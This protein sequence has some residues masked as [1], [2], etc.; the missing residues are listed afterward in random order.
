[1]AASQDFDGVHPS[2]FFKRARILRRFFLGLIALGSVAMV[3]AVPDDPVIL[4]L[5]WRH[6]FQFAGYYAAQA[7]GYYAE[8]GINVRIEPGRPGVSSIDAV[9]NEVAQFGVSDSD[10]V[11]TRLEGKPLVACAAIFQHSPIVI[12][13]RRDRNIRTPADLVGAK[14]MMSDRQG[15]AQLWAMVMREGIAPE[16]VRTVPHS[17]RLEDL[18]EGRVDAISAYATVEPLRLRARGIEPAVLRAIDYGVDFYGDM[19]FTNEREARSHPERTDAF[20]RASLKGWDYALRNPEEIVDLILKLDG[21]KQRG[22]TRESLLEEAAALRPFILPDIVE[23]GHINP[24]R[25]RQ[26]AQTFSDLK[27]VPPGATLEGFIY[28]SPSKAEPLA[29]G[30]LFKAGAATAFGVLLVLLWNLQ[31][32]RRV[33][34]RTRQLKEE[35]LLRARIETELRA[36]EER[37]RLM[38]AGAATG[39]AVTTPDGRFIQANPAYLASVGYSEAELQTL[40]LTALLHPDDQADYRKLVETLLT[41]TKDHFVSEARCLKREGGFTWK[42]ASV[43]LVRTKDGQ[44][45]SIIVV[46]EDITARREAEEAASASAEL[47]RMAS[48]IGGM[49]AWAIEYPGARITWSDE[50][51]RIHEVDTSY[52]PDQESALGFFTPASRSLL[53]AAIDAAE[54]YDLELEL[55]TAKGN[56]RWVRTTSNIEREDGVLKRIYGIFQDITDRKLAREKLTASEAQYRLLFTH[57]P[58]PMWVCEDQTLRFLAVNAAASEHYGYSEAEF[59][60]MTIT[61]LRAPG[62][63]GATER[64][65]TKSG[66][67]IDIEM[68][69]DQIVFDDRPAFLTMAHDV[70]EL[71]RVNR[72]QRMLSACNEALI[73]TEAENDLLNDICRIAVEIGGYRMAWVGFALQ[74]A[75]HSIRPVA[76]AG[77]ESGYLSE[78]ELSWRE[79]L[80]TGRGPAGRTIRSGCAVFCEDIDKDDRFSR[81][82]TLARR[83]GSRGVICLPLRD[84][85]RTRGLLSLHSSEVLAVSPDEIKL[86]QQLADDLA[87]GLN[88]IRARVERQKTQEA[89]FTMARSVSATIGGAFFDQLTHSMVAALGADVGVVAMI[90]P[91]H[92]TLVRTLSVVADGI[93][94]ENFTYLLTGAPC[95]Q[96]IPGES[97]VI[98]RDVQQRFPKSLLMAELNAQAY[99]GHPLVTASG[100]R[101]GVMAVLFRRPLEQTEFIAS[102]LQIF[103]TRA[104]SELDRQQVDS[105][106]REQAALLDKAQ[107]A[108][109]VRDLEHHI[110]FWNKSAERLYGWTAEEALGRSIAE[111]LYEEPTAFLEATNQVVTKGEWVGEL[112][113]INK[114]RI[115]LVVECRWTL[116]R[117]DAGTP[118]S[119]LAIN[120]DITEK[121]RLEH[122]F[123]RAQRMESIGTLAG[124]IAHDLNNVL[125]PVIMAVDLLRLNEKDPH[126]LSLLGTVDASARRG[127]DMVGQVL[128]F[129]RGMEGRRVEVQL[130]HVIH[131]IEKI[132]HDTF[133]KN[134]QISADID[135]ALWP[136]I[137]DPTQLHQVLLNLCVNA[138]DAMINGG[139]LTLRAENVHLDAHYAAMNI[140]AKAGPHVIIEVEDTGTGISEAIIHKIFDP[141]F[142]T[143]EVGKGTGLGLSTSI[144]I[145]KGHDGFIR[146]YS[147][148]GK[149]TRF[150][151]YLPAKPSVDIP[152]ATVESTDLPRGRGELVLVVDDEAPIREITKVTLET[153]GYQVMLAVDGAEA[154]ALYVAHCERIAVVLTDMMMPVMDGPAAIHALVKI[155]PSI[156]IIAAS[157]IT[158]N[159]SVAKAVGFGVKHF[160]PK[161]Y[162][163]ST[164]LKTLRQVLQDTP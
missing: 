26:I 4:W 32:R 70:T 50:V 142:T 37:F 89:V 106:V 49:G 67:L 130:R 118:R 8:E 21:V 1:M 86:L 154:V 88:I 66:S 150:R 153:F 62:P 57:N 159:G 163:A 6:Q 72:A 84:E 124:G 97:C 101:V 111:L 123:L 40:H 158:A 73:R 44:P 109:L 38:F 25:F 68:S 30:M 87:F 121:K 91:A 92:P 90:D 43:S 83:H 20:I 110:T 45:A 39:I 5:K 76:H 71:A 129:A 85:T 135:K 133:P 139:R 75:G 145:I 155:N 162:T 47:L 156:R 108:I 115:R 60:G 148:P 61:D 113:Q 100:Q 95:E 51:F 140:E 114:Q 98:L 149:G 126:K 96:V 164:L 151:V 125:S 12:L 143:K 69:S 132:S 16:M 146:V 58:L 23:I 59:L 94:R 82:R 105:R 138:R 141:F 46:A 79:D 56:H 2:Y 117:D 116:V 136:L 34:Q 35:V 131:D 28:A 64:H 102:T 52:R 24:G 19:L 152:A 41:G 81:W 63:A 36:S 13:S 77:A 65:R 78:I 93:R 107:D 103:A 74:D 31:I 157:G 134:I 160:L 48:G 120:T 112:H 42:R 104:S 18:I 3:Q 128:S 27:M 122:Q 33:N 161:P 10:I 137:G 80:P 15:S 144:A 127:A 99:V 9:L 14:I 54:P 119:V 17:W 147:E 11:L 7:K 29:R 53:K 22:A 55:I